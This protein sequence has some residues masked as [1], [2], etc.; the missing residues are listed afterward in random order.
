VTSAAP[1]VFVATCDLSAQLRGRS[2]PISRL[3]QVLADGLGWVPANLAI[4]AAGPLATGERFG[5]RGDLRLAPDQS[6]VCR[7]P[8]DGTHPAVDL[9]LADQTEI[10]G[11]PWS[12]CPRTFLR[13]AIADLAAA[14]LYVRAAFEHEFM[15]RDADISSPFSWHRARAAEPFGTDLV[16]LLEQVGLE[17]ETWLPEFG[18]G[19]FEITLVPAAAL[20]AADRAVL[21]RELVRDLARRRGARVTFA[22]LPN[23]DGVGNGVHVHF[24]LTDADGR[25]ALFDPARPGQLSAR[26]GAFAAGILRHAPALTALTAASAVSFQRLVPHRWSVGGIYLAERDREALLRICPVPGRGDAAQDAAAF[27]LEFRAADATA[28]PWLVLG[29]LIR[30][31]LHGLQSDY[32][33]AAVSTDADPS[34]AL[35]AEPLPASLDVAL[36]AL[37][38]DE[39]VSGWLDPRLR[40]TYLAVKRAD[41]AAVADLSEHE[42]CEWVADVY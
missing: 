1:I 21:L 38:A 42:Q 3:D 17:P 7:V 11:R 41:L 8:A 10:D 19:Q 25:P 16:T 30:A 20:V 23:P 13:D 14:G 22:P 36:A 28:N 34:P 32:P 4:T 24:S 15:V 35:A 40:H 18:P 37:E 9:Y 27:N 31:G 33:P 39:V 12:C 26:G 5:S 6:T 2:A 29:G